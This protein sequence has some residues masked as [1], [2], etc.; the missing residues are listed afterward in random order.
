MITAGTSRTRTKRHTPMTAR[1]VRL[2]KDLDAELVALASQEGE[3]I[4]DMLLMLWREAVASRKREAAL[5]RQRE[6]LIAM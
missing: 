1:L 3:Y 6:G 4:N 2:P 5:L